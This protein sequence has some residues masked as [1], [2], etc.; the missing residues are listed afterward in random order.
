[1]LCAASGGVQ[2]IVM[3]SS[4]PPEIS[5][6]TFP[7]DLGVLYVPKGSADNY[8]WAEVWS[9]FSDIR[10][11]RSP[12]DDVVIKKVA[13]NHDNGTTIQLVATVTPSNATLKDIYWSSENK[14]LSFKTELG[15]VLYMYRQYGDIMIGYMMRDASMEELFRISGIAV[16]IFI[17]IILSK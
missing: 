5:S 15:D 7:K 16:P 11:I 9:E 13:E 2:K 12:V 6:Y 1:M 8:R 10:E 3:H 14:V 4:T 17:I